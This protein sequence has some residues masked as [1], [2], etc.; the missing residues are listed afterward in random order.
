MPVGPGKYDDLCTF[1]LIQTE[2]KLSALIIIGGNKGSGFSVSS[3]HP[4][5]LLLLA[6]TLQEIIDEVR[7][8]TSGEKTDG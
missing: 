4:D 7:S 3:L 1:S 2:A 8:L 5:Y 6:D